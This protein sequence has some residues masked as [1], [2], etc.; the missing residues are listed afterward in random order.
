MPRHCRTFGGSGVHLQDYPLEQYIR[1][2]KIDTLYEGTTAIQGQDFFFRKIVRNKGAALGALSAEITAFLDSIEDV[3]R[4]K[5]EAAAVRK[6]VED[7][8]GMVGAMFNQLM[9]SQD[10]ISNVYKIGQ[11]TTRLLLSAGDL[12]IGYLLLR[13]ASIA[14]KRL[15]EN[16]LS[17]ADRSFYAGKPAVARFFAATVLPELAARRLT[18]EATD[19]SLMELPES[20]F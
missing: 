15:D 13:Q 11:N 12:M 9:A 20:S 17:E 5:D 16:E 4:L 14:L 8:S 6:A 2:A 7:F 18:V 1:D 3:G 19:N 10:D